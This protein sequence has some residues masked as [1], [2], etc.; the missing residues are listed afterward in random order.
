M[1]CKCVIYQ[2]VISNLSSVEFGFNKDF[3]IEL[4]QLLWL[5]EHPAALIFGKG[6]GI[7]VFF[8]NL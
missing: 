2:N 3:K 7:L 1:M 6:V 4:E 8:Y 5:R